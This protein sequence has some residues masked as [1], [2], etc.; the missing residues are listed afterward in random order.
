MHGSLVYEYA[1]I[2]VMP[3]VDRGEVINVGIIVFCKR[4]RFIRLKYELNH[5]RLSAL[6]PDLDIEEVGSYLTAW[7]LISRGDREGG[8]IARLD[9]PDRFRWITAVKSTILQA[10]R[11]HPGLCDSPE[12]V[13]EHLFEKYVSC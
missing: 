1:V 7:D 13:L 8:P 11:I 5:E 12:D 4:K 6:F 2:R 9:V 3:R 10:S